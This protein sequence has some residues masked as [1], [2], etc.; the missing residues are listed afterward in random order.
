LAIVLVL[1]DVL[2]WTRVAEH[3][4][5]AN[6]WYPLLATEVAGSGPIDIV[7]ALLL[8]VSAAA[9][10]RSWRTVAAVAFGL[11][12]AVKLL[13]DRPAAPLLEACSCARRSVGDS[14]GRTPV[15]TI[16]HAQPDSDRLARHLVSALMIQ[17]SQP[18]SEWRL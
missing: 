10:V 9:L 17:C 1:L 7:G 3:W 12:V 14:R 4:I 18:L 11:A 6:A 5:L 8:L 2:R 13:P 15:P 16:S